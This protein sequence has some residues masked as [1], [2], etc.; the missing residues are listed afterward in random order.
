MAV[1]SNQIYS[2]TQ[3]INAQ[4]LSI[5]GRQEVLSFPGVSL[6]EYF[7]ALPH[8]FCLRIS[9]DLSVSW[10][11]RFLIACA[12]SSDNTVLGWPRT[13]ANQGCSIYVQMV[14]WPLELF[15]LWVSWE[16]PVSLTS[17]FRDA[18]YSSAAGPR[19]Q[20]LSLSLSLLSQK[21]QFTQQGVGWGHVRLH[22]V[23]LRKLCFSKSRTPSTIMF[24]HDF[25]LLLGSRH[26]KGSY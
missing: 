15:F 5:F 21:G 3:N 14:C 6:P 23:L 1:K 18:W 10:G 12:S 4:S 7:W 2:T 16:M 9:N 19:W 17:S 22:H 13:S 24:S 11:Q 26:I 20:S 25:V 8:R